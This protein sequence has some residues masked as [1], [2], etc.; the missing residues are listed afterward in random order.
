MPSS[1]LL[2]RLGRIRF[3]HVGYKSGVGPA[4]EREVAELLAEEVNV[5]KP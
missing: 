4:L 3:R 2:D 5:A 1:Y